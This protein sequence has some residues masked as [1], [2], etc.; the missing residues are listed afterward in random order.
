MKPAARVALII[1]LLSALQALAL[2]YM[3]R[4]PWCVCEEFV[5]WKAEA[6]SSHTS[7]HLLDPY[8]FSHVQHGIIFFLILYLCRVPLRWGLWIACVTEIGWEVLENSSFIINRY[9][10]ATA[11]LDYFGDSIGN[12][13]G[14]LWCALLGFYLARRLPW[15]VTLGLYLLM[16]IGMLLTIKDCLSLNIIML[17]YPIQSIKTWQT[18]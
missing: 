14:D 6:W 12:S 10:A 5:V 1:A 11:S 3:D 18:A 13:I 4:L 15:K 9:R 8:S 16:E 2:I 17:I 7:Q